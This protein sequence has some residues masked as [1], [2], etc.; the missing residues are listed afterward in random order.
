MIKRTA[1]GPMTVTRQIERPGVALYV[2]A[3]S[4]KMDGT[5][6]DANPGKWLNPIFEQVHTEAAALK[7]PEVVLDIRALTYANASFFRCLVM[8]MRRIEAD[9][10]SYRVR[11][12]TDPAQRW[13]KIGVAALIEFGEDR[14]VVQGERA[15]FVPPAT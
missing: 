15:S 14:L 2:T 12:L 6:R 11:I 1:S 13:Q 4:I 5:V 10:A 3:E 7:L 9:A 8:W